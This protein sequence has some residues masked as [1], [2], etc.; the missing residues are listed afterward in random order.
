MALERI[1]RS[2][3][4]TDVDPV[5]G[6]ARAP[7]HA[8]SAVDDDGVTAELTGVLDGPGQPVS[9]PRRPRVRAPPPTARPARACRVSGAGR[10]GR[11]PRAAARAYRSSVPGEYVCSSRARGS[12]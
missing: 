9:P 8:D 4:G 2:G 1:D 6:C 5:V 10:F 11:C 7:H 12:P 3:D